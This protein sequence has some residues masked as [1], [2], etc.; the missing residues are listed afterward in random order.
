MINAIGVGLLGVDAVCTGLMGVSALRWEGTETAK[1]ANTAVAVME[2]AA[3]VGECLDPESFVV[4]AVDVVVGS[5]HP[6]IWHET[7]KVMDVTRQNQE[8]I[9]ISAGTTFA[10]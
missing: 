8:D 6:R 5:F 9:P 7:S 4:V 10:R 3:L 1:R 2:V